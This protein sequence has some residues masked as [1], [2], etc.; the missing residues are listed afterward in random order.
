[1]KNIDF[2]Y[3]RTRQKF[4]NPKNII[5]G[6]IRNR[7][8]EKN[9]NSQQRITTKYEKVEQRWFLAFFFRSNGNLEKLKDRRQ[10]QKSRK[11][12]EYIEEHLLTVRQMIEKLIDTNALQTP[13]VDLLSCSSAICCKGYPQLLR[14]MAVMR[15]V[16]TWKKRGSESFFCRRQI[17]RHGV[18]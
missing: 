13:D 2:P 11:S 16:M 14:N 8:P 3:A 12:Q 10:S 18:F 6:F 9:E 17:E 4:Q 5:M 15:N 1:M 7:Q